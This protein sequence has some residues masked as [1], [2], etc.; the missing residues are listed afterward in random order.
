MCLSMPVL[1]APYLT[2]K[3]RRW[4]FAITNNS[5]S[6]YLQPTL[7]R[8]VCLPFVMLHSTLWYGY[9]SFHSPCFP[10]CFFLY[11]WVFGFVSLPPSR[12]M[13]VSLRLNL[14]ASM[15]FCVLL[16]YV[17]VALLREFHACMSSFSDSLFAFCESM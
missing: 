13:L 15:V 2:F 4:P 11:S 16:S 3:R 7:L 5:S 17:S 6:V 12:Y 1:I 10:V 8:Y 14:H 9:V